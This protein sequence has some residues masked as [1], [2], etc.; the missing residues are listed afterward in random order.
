MARRKEGAVETYLHGQV[1]ALGGTTRKFVS[2]GHRG[3]P[4][5]ILLWP[6]GITHFAETKGSEDDKVKSHQAREHK[7]FRDLGHRVEV[8]RTKEAVDRYIEQ[9]RKEFLWIFQSPSRSSK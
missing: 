3:V 5:R 1:W 7:R 4:D 9:F 6:A 8:L 2:P